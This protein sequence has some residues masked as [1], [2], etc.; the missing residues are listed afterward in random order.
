MDFRA[1]NEKPNVVQFGK[2]TP[3]LILKYKALPDAKKE[4]GDIA[5]IRNTF[6]SFQSY[7]YDNRVA[8]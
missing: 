6:I 4:L 8:I 1:N 2:L 3:L 7:L 5:S